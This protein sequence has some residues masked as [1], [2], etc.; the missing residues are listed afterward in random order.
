MT[1]STPRGAKGGQKKQRGTEATEATDP[2][3]IETVQEVLE[4]KLGKQ[5]AQ[6]VVHQLVMSYSGP[7]PLPEP[8]KVYAE[9]IPNGGE[10]IMVMA[11]NEQKHRHTIENRISS[12]GA[13]DSKTDRTLAVRGQWMAYSVFILLV[14][15]GVWAMMTDRFEAGYWQFG[16]AGAAYVANALIIKLVNRSGR[17]SNENEKK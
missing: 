1:R 11:E 9:L 13:D 3:S 4:A 8:F 14:G 2:V 10:R 7:L 5:A 16:F 15:G 12:I 17:G 6:S